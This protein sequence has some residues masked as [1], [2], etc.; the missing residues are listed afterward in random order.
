MSHP[1]PITVVIIDDHPIVRAGM[2]SVLDRD[3]DIVVV[4]EG[5]SGKDALELV[6]T[7]APQ[8][9]ED[10]WE[11][12]KNLFPDFEKPISVNVTPVLGAHLG[13]KTVGFAFIQK[14]W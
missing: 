11:K 3:E 6:E 5:E 8:A 14:E 9:A 12:V 13:P 1:L 2:R 7:N 4:A 10:L